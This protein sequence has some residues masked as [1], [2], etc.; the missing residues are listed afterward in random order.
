MPTIKFTDRSIRALKPPAEGRVEYWDA[1]LPGLGLRVS[2]TGKKSWVLMYRTHGGRQ[3]RM[4][5][6]QYG[7]GCGFADARKIAGKHLRE[8]ANGGD[9]AGD[10][11]RSGWQR[12]SVSWPTSISNNT[13]RF[14]R[15]LGGR[16]MVL[17]D[18][19]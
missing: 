7:P 5:L 19:I 11:K 9:P 13:P 17:S 10:K 16:T 6:G 1:D 4:T 12:R 2:G 8:V 3:R 18:A 15:N 14:T